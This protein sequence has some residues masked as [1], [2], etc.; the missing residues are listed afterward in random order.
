MTIDCK[1]K[2]SIAAA[3]TRED[4]VRQAIALVRDDILAKV[5]GR[6]I[7]KPNFLSSVNPLASTRPGAVRPVL[8]LALVA[9]VVAL[10]WPSVPGWGVLP[11]LIL[12]ALLAI[13]TAALVLFVRYLIRRR[14]GTD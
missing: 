6:V 13:P 8:G 7:I 3:S 5:K 14:K 1:T 4:C 11:S 10:G 12:L 2:V 9:R